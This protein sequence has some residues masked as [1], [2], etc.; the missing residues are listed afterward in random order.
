MSTKK[1]RET[2]QKVK[3]EIKNQISVEKFL[4][5]G[6]RPVVSFE[7]VIVIKGCVHVF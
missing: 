1:S 6:S 2:S 7:Y 3:N 4:R 5:S